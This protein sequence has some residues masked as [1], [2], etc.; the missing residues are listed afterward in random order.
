MKIKQHHIGT[1][2]FIVL[3]SAAFIGLGILSHNPTPTAKKNMTDQ[4]AERVVLATEAAM[5]NAVQT[6]WTMIIVPR[7]N[8]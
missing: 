2:V 5:F 4:E 7:T 1:F 8:Q 3:A 6:N